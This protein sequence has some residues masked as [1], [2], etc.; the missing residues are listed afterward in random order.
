MA[1]LLLLGKQLTNTFHDGC[2]EGQVD[3]L[4]DKSFLTKKK[5]K[6]FAIF[7]IE[8]SRVSWKVK[9]WDAQSQ[10]R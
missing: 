5:L 6:Q 2:S 9:Q 8:D 10:R 7:M 4:G 1:V 3:D